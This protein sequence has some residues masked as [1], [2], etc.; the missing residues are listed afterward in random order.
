MASLLR[1]L[2]I[3]FILVLGM[4]AIFVVVT[5][6]RQ[7]EVIHDN[8][9]QLLL[10]KGKDLQASFENVSALAAQG[11]WDDVNAIFE[12]ARTSGRLD[13]Y[14]LQNQGQPVWFGSWTD[15]LED[16]DMKWPVAKEPSVNPQYIFESLDLGSGYQLTAG[17]LQKWDQ[18][19]E[20][21]RVIHIHQLIEEYAYVLLIVLVVGFYSLKDI[22]SIVRQV[23]RGKRGELANVTATSSEANL[24]LQSLRGYS[25]AVS[26]LEAENIRLGRQVLPSL[27]KE[28]H[29]G[30]KP[31]YD[32]DCTMVRTDINNFSLIF[33]THNVT[34]F[35]ATINEFFDEVSRIV[36]RYGGLIHEFVGD[37]VIYYFKDDEHENSF[38]VALSAVRDINELAV[39]FH[40]ST[41]KER[42]YA[43]TV[44]SSLA[45]GRVR[46]GPLV[47]GFTI[48][49][50]VL[51][52]T[53][54]I[55]SNIVEK[56]DNVVYFDGVNESRVKGF[57]QSM[58]RLRVKMKGYQSE[59]GLHQYVTHLPLKHV[60]DHLSFESVSLLL[61]Y[62]SD[63]DL[64]FVL[65][66]L[67]THVRD[68]QMSLKAVM[69]LREPYVARHSPEVTDA[70]RDWLESLLNS[71]A[72]VKILSAAVKLYINLVP[73]EGFTEADRLLLTKILA[74]EDRRVVANAVEVLTHFS[75]DVTGK[76]VKIRDDLRILANSIVHDGRDE[77]TPATLKSIRGLLKSK[78]ANEVASGLYALGEL[79]S[80]HRSRDFAYYSAQLDFQSLVQQIDVYAQHTT[81]MVRRQALTAARKAAND[82]VISRIRDHVKDSGSEL[83]TEE[84]GRYLDQ[85]KAA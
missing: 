22:S 62:R 2:P 27:Q 26:D 1:R 29:S 40:A 5:Y 10:D 32:F 12:N 65:T 68:E 83:L 11:R 46:F 66:N 51:I 28:I 52:E 49:G 39:K 41:T 15:N 37:E 24:F 78:K 30:R 73:R 8:Y 71:A 31:P 60:M 58:E 25:Q 72:S 74:S 14:I 16:V 55:L 9:N 63:R 54:R 48:A 47:G 3:L 67:K 20:A 44:K 57:I 64:K 13:F 21:N 38:A 81:T 7:R 50:A 35:M 42:G 84:L 17:F 23:R 76:V 45:H 33:N 53:V 77:L 75:T 59:V 6:Q 70:L 36:A 56:D 82:E 79:A 18:Y 19:Y 34:E 43:F 80:M 69:A 85:G 4:S 61:Y